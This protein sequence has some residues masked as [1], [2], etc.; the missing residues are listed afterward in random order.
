[1]L[2]P[3]WDY[4]F[5]LN[6]QLSARIPL[7]WLLMK[8]PSMDDLLGLFDRRRRFLNVFGRVAL[9]AQQKSAGNPPVAFLMERVVSP[10]AVKLPCV[11]SDMDP[12]TW[13]SHNLPITG[14]AV[15]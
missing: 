6:H 15:P 4:R 2:P 14:R 1:M 13:R 10:R 7:L 8:F 9:I 12:F 3:A 5:R 11:T